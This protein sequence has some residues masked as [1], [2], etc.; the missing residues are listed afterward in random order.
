[1]RIIAVDWSGRDARAEEFIWIA[2]VR[3][4]RLDFLENGRDRGQAIAWLMAQA[5]EDPD[6]VVGLDFAFSFPAWYCKRRGWSSAIDA[7][8]AIADGEGERLLAECPP[9]F[10]GRPG[11]G[12]PPGAHE[13]WRRTER[14]DAPSAKSVFQIGGSGAVGTGSIRGMG[15]LLRLH[16]AGF[17]VWPFTGSGLPIALEIYP[18][19]MYGRSVRKSRWRE[20]H[21]LL[22]RRF[23]DQPAELRERA[24][25]SQD[26]F[27]AAVSA[28][29]MSQHA[30]QLSALARD[31]AFA[32][33]GRVWAP[34]ATE[35]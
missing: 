24:A 18:R 30:A 7:W 13:Q 26:A 2:G 16:E 25:G 8:S 3:D 15:Q 6:L 35:P 31:P 33:E 17:A 12:R 20:R 23:A 10:W 21:A 5:A 4:G 27:D 1:M 14:V 32:L 29:V 9:P 28:L 11:R 22:L 19:L 34:R